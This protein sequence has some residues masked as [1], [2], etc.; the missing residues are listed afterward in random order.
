MSDP[1]TAWALVKQYGVTP[2]NAQLVRHAVYT[3]KSKLA[4]TWMDSRL[5]LIGDAAHVMPPFMGQGM[6]SGVRDAN[7]LAWKLDTVLRGLADPAILGSYQD[8]R[9]PHVASIINMSIDAGKVSCTTDPSVA[10]ARDEAFRTGQVPPPPPF[11]H[12][13]SGILGTTD[14]STRLRGHLAPQG[15]IALAGQEGRFDDV[16]GTGWTLLLSGE[17][18]PAFNAEQQSTLDRLNVR[19]VAIAE[20]PSASAA[21]D[22]DGYYARYFAANAVSAVLYRPDFYV[23]GAAD[24]LASTGSLIDELGSL[25]PPRAQAAVA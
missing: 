1:A 6:C 2:D 17:T 7:N 15:R 22:I 11:P 3:F 25:V 19:V 9:A 18:V 24:D 23:F 5:L 21:T 10:A 13:E 16:L 12:L 4:D 8:E 20:D 14:A